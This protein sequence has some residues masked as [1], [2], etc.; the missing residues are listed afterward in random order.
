MPPREISNTRENRTGR[1]VHLHPSAR[2]LNQYARIGD[3]ISYR[4]DGK[5]STAIAEMVEIA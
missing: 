4:N 1:S 3:L 5:C 2:R